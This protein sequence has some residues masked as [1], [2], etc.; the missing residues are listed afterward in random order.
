MWAGGVKERGG[1][2]Y[3]KCRVPCEGLLQ[4]LRSLSVRGDVCG[5]A[6]PWEFQTGFTTY[7]YAADPVHRSHCGSSVLHFPRPPIFLHV[8]QWPQGKLGG[9]GCV[10]W[11]IVQQPGVKGLLSAGL[12]F[13]MLSGLAS[14]SR[15]GSGGDNNVGNVDAKEHGRHWGRKKPNPP[16]TTARSKEHYHTPTRTVNQLQRTINQPRNSHT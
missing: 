12:T 2:N 10:P 5:D 8:S 9:L 16:G 11:I 13:G 14:I 15:C 7:T 1:H 4:S 6:S 3:D